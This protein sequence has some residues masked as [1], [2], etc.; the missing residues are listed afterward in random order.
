MATAATSERLLRVVRE[1]GRN[2]VVEPSPSA[3]TGQVCRPVFL[4]SLGIP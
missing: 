1:G 4:F 3:G 2:E